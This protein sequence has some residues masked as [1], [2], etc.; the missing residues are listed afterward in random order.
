MRALPLVS[1]AD[2]IAALAKIGYRTIRQKG[3]HVRLVSPGKPPVTVPLHPEL[4][5][6]T[7]EA[8]YARSNSGWMTLSH[9]SGEVQR[10]TGVVFATCSTAGP[11]CRR[12]GSCDISTPSRLISTG[13]DS[14]GS[15]SAG[16]VSGG[17][18]ASACS[19]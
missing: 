17:M 18:R 7:C 9:C 8:S 15:T 11:M 3:S 19:M 6:G 14:T 13:Y 12:C 5:R 16:G 10:D 4:D 1:G 2:C